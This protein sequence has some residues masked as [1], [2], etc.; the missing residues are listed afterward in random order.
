MNVRES[1]FLVFLFSFFL[2]IC[3]FLSS[4]FNF[5][6]VILSF[7]FFHC[8][9]FLLNHLCLFIMYFLFVIIFF[10]YV[11]LN[12]FSHLSLQTFLLHSK[13]SEISFRC[14]IVLFSVL[15]PGRAAGQGMIFAVIT[16]S[17]GYLNQPKSASPLE[18]GI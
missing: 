13:T 15:P 7:I 1:Y 12:S 6:A 5:F 10:F 3:S 17:T 9:F 2:I 11:L 14:D 8:F 4:I 16:I 18:Q